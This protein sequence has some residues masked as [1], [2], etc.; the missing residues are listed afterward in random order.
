MSDFSPTEAALEGLRISRERPLA[1]LWW[2]AAYVLVGV[3]HIALA[4]IAPF[5]RLAAAYPD[6]LAA[7]DAARA[8]PTDVAASQHAMLLFAQ[9]L[10]ALTGLAAVTLVAQMVFS[11]AV[12]RAVLRPAEQ[13]FGYLRLST[14]EARQLGLALLITVAVIG[15]SFM[16]SLA[17]GLLLGLL[18]AF[19]PPALLGLLAICIVLVAFAY[20]G[21][22]LSLAPAMTLADGRIS[23]LR[24]WALTKGQFWPLLGAFVLALAIA[25][26]LWLA[27]TAPIGLALK[28]AGGRSD[29]AVISGFKDLA[30]PLPLLA[31][32]VGSL[33]QALVAA[34][35]TAPIASAFR[36]I[37]GRVGAPPAARPGATGSPWS[38][39]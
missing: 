13:R 36:Q 18:A 5:D 21:V 33:V 39:V 38:Q 1:V 2:W 8:N 24:A 19:L 37:A 28:L 14:D 23:F 10:P 12:L 20:P 16:V 22:R 27:V 15:Y 7:S 35:I 17:S 32:V 30:A 26:V 25:A 31:L 4:S 3:L 11:T 6:L 9:V 34:I 29:P